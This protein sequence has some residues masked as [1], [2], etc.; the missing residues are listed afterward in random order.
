MV[1]FEINYE[2]SDMKAFFNETAKNSLIKNLVWIYSL[3]GAVIFIIFAAVTFFAKGTFSF[4]RPLPYIFL[5]VLAVIVFLAI[6]RTVRNTPE[7]MYSKFSESYDGNTVI[8]RF[9]EDRVYIESENA[10]DSNNGFIK[11]S[12]LEKVVE[13]DNYFYVFINQSTA[14]IVRKSAVTEGDTDDVRNF[15]KPYLADNYEDIR[16]YRK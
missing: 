6:S 5:G 8:C 16:K 9:D 11:Y 1:K 7:K 4:A 10:D 14:Q 15:L 2:K 3:I 13:S 12:E